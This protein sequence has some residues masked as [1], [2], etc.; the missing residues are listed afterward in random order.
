MRSRGLL[1]S[2]VLLALAS[3]ALARRTVAVNI[4]GFDVPANGNREICVLVT[5]PVKDA[6]DIGEVLIRN[7][8]AGG[9]FATHHMIVYA[10]GGDLDAVAGDIGRVVDDTACLDFGGGD[11]TKLGI[12]ATSQAIKHRE[13]IPAGTALRLQPGTLRG[14]KTIGLVLNSHWINGESRPH[15]ARVAVKLVKARP[16]SVKR[17]LLPIFEVFANGMLQVPPGETRDVGFWW[18]P[19]GADLGRFLGGASSPTGPAC[20]TMLI[21]H[22]HRRGTLFTADLVDRDGNRRRLYENT[23]YA[24][25]PAVRFGSP[26]LVREGD[27]IE[28]RCTHDNASDP[29]LGCEEEA[30]VTPGL[31]VIDVIVQRGFSGNVDGSAK[32][33]TTPGDD[34]GECPPGPDP[35]NPS[36]VFTGRCVPA[37]LVFGFLSEDDMCILPGYYYDADPAA[38]P[39]EECAL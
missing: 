34:P 25:P 21:G 15:R 22:M 5:V 2:L 28:Y 32:L 9:G 13:P 16:S 6:M 37:N 39:G 8:G 33:C 12:V 24:D 1:A 11:P 36:R 3:P 18:G 27:R 35:A 38:A 10:Y 26:L 14:R 4:P 19:G 17:P 31:S 23:R 7:R 20:V 29:R 30:G